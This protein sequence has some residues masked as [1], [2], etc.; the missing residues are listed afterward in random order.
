MSSISPYN[1]EKIRNLHFFAKNSIQTSEVCY[2][3][4]IRANFLQHYFQT[5]IKQSRCKKFL[6]LLTFPENK[7]EPRHAKISTFQRWHSLADARG[8]YGHGPQRDF[9][10]LPQTG[11]KSQG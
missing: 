6:D 5:I 7:T 3:F 4:S 2:K 1:Q 10:S 9:G 8:Q 11:R